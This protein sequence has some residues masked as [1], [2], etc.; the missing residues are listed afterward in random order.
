M[1]ITEEQV[2]R[3][4]SDGFLIIERIVSDEQVEQ[5]LAAME[6]IYEGVYTRD[7]RP[8][9]M[10]Q[11]VTP[12]GSTNTVRWVLNAR[13]VDADVWSL[14]TQPALARIASRLLRTSSV[15]VIEDQ[16][17][18]KPAQG[19]PV[20]LHQDYSYW[21]FLTST[22]T[23]S[24]W[25]ALSDMTASMGPIELVQGSH[26]WGVATRP[27]Q[28]VHDSSDE[29]TSAAEAVRPEEEPYKFSS[30]IVPKGGGVFF[31]GLTFHGSR[32]NSTD[33]R[34]RALS[35]HWASAEC[36]LDRS[37]LADHDYPY[38][39]AGLKHGDPVKN[40]YFPQVDPGV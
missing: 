18:D 10:R 40:K 36:R 17:L 13:I 35:L 4:D 14:V 26:R 31:H 20:N 27:R 16:L 21:K 25:I 33:Q 7:V 19:V 29:Y 1:D 12:F 11:P 32:G 28:I 30:A 6:R 22:N 2:E 37:K 8:P 39:F 15:S 3:F 24:C 38:Y 9:A 23:I 5:L 34:R